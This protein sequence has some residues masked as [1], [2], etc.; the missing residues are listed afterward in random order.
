MANI[1]EIA[2]LANVSVST[3]SRVLNHHPYVSEEKRKLVHQVMKELD[4]T[5]NRTA[6]DLI[7]G[8]THTVGVILPYSDHPCFDKIVNG[9]TK[10][11]F[12]YEYATT[13][14]PTNYNPDI[15]I[16][17]LELLRTKKIDGLII[18]SRANHWDSI[19]A[20][21]EYGPIIA[22]ED[23]G[24]I[25]VPCAFNDRKTA[26][27]ESFRYLKSRGHENIAFTCVREA[28][29]SPSTAD[30]AA[31]YKAVCGRLEDRHMLSGCNDINDGERAAEHF[32]MS[33]RVPTA[34][35]ANS[36]EVAAGIHLFAKKSNW[37]VEIIGEGNTSISRVLGFPSLDLNLEQLGIAAFSLFL[38]D[39]P[40]DIKIQHK[41]KKKA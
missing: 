29:R 36:D 27:A 31:A 19:L 14:L 32:Y 40:A 30:K 28:D 38:Q 12:Q 15:E 34:I 6:I 23:T 37:D 18:T 4:Y 8:K 39:E 10:A 21:Q 3:V 5:P 11:A 9:I 25:D 41:F 7:R 1:K 2:R 16:K 24:D 26:Y 20:Y 35:Y 13:L 33:G 22:C 17:Y